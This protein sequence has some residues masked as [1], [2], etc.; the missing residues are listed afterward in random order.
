MSS[1]EEKFY[2]VLLTFLA[3]AGFSAFL[4]TCKEALA[5]KNAKE[6]TD[7]NEGK[8]RG[9]SRGDNIIPL[10]YS[11]YAEEVRCGCSAKSKRNISGAL[12]TGGT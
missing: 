9:K 1:A 12:P 7:K 2:T 5:K 11:V 3:R 10:W 8:K 4:C 6:T